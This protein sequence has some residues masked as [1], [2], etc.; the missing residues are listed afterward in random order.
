MMKQMEALLSRARAHQIAI[1]Q[2]TR[3]QR[4]AHVSV[5]PMGSIDRAKVYSFRTCIGHC[6]KCDNIWIEMRMLLRSTG[7]KMVEVRSPKTS[8]P[9]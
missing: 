9:T 8:T 4:Q 1:E 5:T 2:S 6:T 3:N 7:V